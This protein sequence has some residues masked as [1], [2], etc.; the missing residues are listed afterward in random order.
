MNQ[1]SLLCLVPVPVPV[2]LV[3]LP[4]VVVVVVMPVYLLLLLLLDCRHYVDTFCE[5]T[6]RTAEQETAIFL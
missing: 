5:A 1:S 3:D 2:L 6:A 4:L